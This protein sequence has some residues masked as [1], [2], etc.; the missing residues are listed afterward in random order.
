VRAKKE[1][2]AKRLFICFP[3]IDEDVKQV[4]AEIKSGAK[5]E[6]AVGALLFDS[7]GLHIEDSETFPD[8]N[9]ASEIHEYENNLKKALLNNFYFDEIVEMI[10]ELS[11]DTKNGG[12]KE[13]KEEF[14]GRIELDYVLDKLDDLI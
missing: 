6:P 14:Y 4:F 5:E 10:R 13:V 3:L 1:K 2:I 7:K 9:V 8:D 12:F 11:V